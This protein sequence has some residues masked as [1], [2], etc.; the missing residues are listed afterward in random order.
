MNV[1]VTLIV[2]YQ[3]CLFIFRKLISS[4]GIHFVRFT[5]EK[6]RF[7]SKDHDKCPFTCE[8]LNS[9]S[10]RQMCA[11]PRRWAEHPHLLSCHFP[12]SLFLQRSPCNCYMYSPTQRWQ[13]KP[14]TW[15]EVW[16]NK[17]LLGVISN[18]FSQCA[19]LCLP[20]IPWVCVCG[21]LF[22]SPWL[23]L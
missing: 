12:L 18:I 13:P 22:A 6:A 4:L 20:L 23:M 10:G 15:T 3:P 11:R 2:K 16:S 9:F 19:V 5:A 17:H 1:N 21:P 8:W 7:V 14:P